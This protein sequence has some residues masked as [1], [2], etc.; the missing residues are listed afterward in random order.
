MSAGIIATTIHA[1]DFKDAEGDRIVGR[2]TLPII[3]P[4]IARPTLMLVIIL[5]SICLSSLWGLSMAIAVVFNILALT[6]GIRYVSLNSI[7]SDQRSF[8]LYNVG[9]LLLLSDRYK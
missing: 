8:Y 6:V 1:Q 9:V 4:T 7:K 5:W 3:A 2:K